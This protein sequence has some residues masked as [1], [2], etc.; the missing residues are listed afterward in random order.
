MI[1]LSPHVTL[2]EGV[3][4]TTATRKGIDNTPSDKVIEKMKTTAQMI[5]EP[6]RVQFGP[7]FISSFYRSAKLNRSIGG[8]THSQ[9]CKGEA[10]DLDRDVYGEVTH[11]ELYDWVRANLEYDQLIF[12]F[13][14]WVHISYRAGSNRLMSFEMA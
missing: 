8:S 3:R 12:E 11:R 5:Y 10:I 14:S 7:V 9:H 4:S 2:H 1:L 13:S 6:I